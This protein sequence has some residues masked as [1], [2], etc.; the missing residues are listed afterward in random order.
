MRVAGESEFPPYLLF[1]PRLLK[2]TY[3][4]WRHPTTVPLRV[5]PQFRDLLLVIAILLDGGA[6]KPEDLEKFLGLDNLA[7]NGDNLDTLDK[8]D[9]DL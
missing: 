4:R 7:D 6:I 9:E 2:H 5:P 3:H 1:M 8:L